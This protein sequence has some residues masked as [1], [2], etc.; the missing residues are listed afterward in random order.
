MTRFV[1]EGQSIPNYTCKDNYKCM[2][3]KIILTQVGGGVHTVTTHFSDLM[4]KTPIFIKELSYKD[5]IKNRE[6]WIAMR[7]S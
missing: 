7:L 3:L 1:S 4:R 2:I 5:I 6:I